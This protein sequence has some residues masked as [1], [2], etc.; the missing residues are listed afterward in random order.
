M[1]IL[2]ELLQED[3]NETLQNKENRI[4]LRTLLEDYGYTEIITEP[5]LT[6]PM[7]KMKIDKTPEWSSDDRNCQVHEFERKRRL[8]RYYESDQKW[9]ESTF[10][11]ADRPMHKKEEARIAQTLEEQR[12]IVHIAVNDVPAF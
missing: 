4:Q 5:E 3:K 9:K 1:G 7:Q 12:H 2:I 11:L 10:G 8:S 6:Q